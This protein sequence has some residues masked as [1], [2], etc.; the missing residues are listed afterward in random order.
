MAQITADW[1]PAGVTWNSRPASICC[2]DA[3]SS[4]LSSPTLLSWN[5]QS[6]VQQWVGDPAHNPNYGFLI[7]GT[8]G[9]GNRAPSAAAWKAL[10]PLNDH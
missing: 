8:S 4:P 2:T 10:R 3:V 1:K 9:S 7:Q 5:V 6:L